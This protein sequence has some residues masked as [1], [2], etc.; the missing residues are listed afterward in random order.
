MTTT[1]RPPFP[2]PD[3]GLGHAWLL[4]GQEPVGVSERFSRAYEEQ[5][6]ELWDAFEARGWVPALE[7]AGSQDGEAIVGRDA[8]GEI[9]CFLHL[10]EP[11]G[12]EEIASARRSG[13]LQELID[14][15]CA[16]A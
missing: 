3:D 8:E 4:M 9:M 11:M 2:R 15:E 6:A 10:E 7:C 1:P 12:A 13:R 5:A 14:E 16:G